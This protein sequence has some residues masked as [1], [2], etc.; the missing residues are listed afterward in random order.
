MN[1]W[2][3][4]KV[5]FSFYSPCA[6]KQLQLGDANFTAQ[7]KRPWDAKPEARK[8]APGIPKASLWAYDPNGINQVGCIYTAQGFESDYVG[9]IVGP[10]LV[11]NFEKQTWIGDPTRSA[12]SVV[13]R[14]KEKFL[15]LI[16]NTYRVL[17]TRGM[18]G[19]YVYFMDKDT[20]NFVKSR[21][22]E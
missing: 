13:K 5:S 2:I 15:E 8:L 14:S 3:F 11:Y 12:D 21:I 10:D 20:E 16:K 6:K 17:L 9:V 22:E 4:I 1:S 7:F 19:C 18:K